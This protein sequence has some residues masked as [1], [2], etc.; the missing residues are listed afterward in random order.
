MY[1]DE[2]GDHTYKH[3]DN[4]DTRYLGLTGV[5]ILKD[6]YDKHVR[7]ELEE[8]KRRIFKYDP[9]DPPILVRSMIRNRKRWFYVLQDEA[10][11]KQ[12]EEELINFIQGLERYMQVFTVVIDKKK[13][14]RDYP[15]R[16]FDPYAYSLS[17]LLNRSRGFLMK[18]HAKADI[19]VE[20][21]GRVEDQ[22]IMRAYVSLRTTGSLYGKA[23]DYKKAYPVETLIL[24]RKETNIAGLQL[25]D[26]I[27][28]GQ[29]VQTVLENNKPYT[30]Q[31]SGFTKRLNTA[32]NPMVNQYGRYLLE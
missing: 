28:F 10:L 31:L 29:K 20:A 5:L 15:V 14:L 22:Q 11:N 23:A 18:M 30:R 6:Y 13:H 12:W 19:L 1:I 24:K 8:L 4:L 17:V 26:I 3:T 25:A 32:V 27:A 9:D 16:T 21:R 7:S 2:S